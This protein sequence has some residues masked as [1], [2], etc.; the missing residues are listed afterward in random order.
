[1]LYVKK[2]LPSNFLASGNKTIEI[3][4]AELNLRNVKMLINYFYSNYKVK[5][6][7]HLAALNACSDKHSKNM[8]KI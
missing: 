6:G 2:D 7:T 1:M 8:V 4:Y 5:I 3:F